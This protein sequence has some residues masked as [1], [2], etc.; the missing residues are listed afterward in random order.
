MT[1]DEPGERPP[2]WR[3]GGVHRRPSPLR[4]PH[5]RVPTKLAAV[6][7]V[8]LLG[9]LVVTGVQITDSVR[10][11]SGLN[12]FSQQVKLGVE[13]TGLVHELQ[14]ERDRTV[15]MLAALSARRSQQ[16]DVG[17]LAPEW[18]AVDRAVQ[19]LRARTRPLLGSDEALA[20]V[21]ARADVRLTDLARVRE[22]VTQGWLRTQAVFDLYSSTIADLQALLPAGDPGGDAELGRQVRG[23]TDLARAKEL[24][25][26][27]RGQLYLLCRSYGT[28][29]EN[30][31]DSRIA[32]LR[33]QRT[34][35]LARFRADAVPAQVARFDDTVAGQAVR[36][37][38]RLEQLIAE[39]GAAAERG[40]DAQQW[41]MASTTELQLLRTVEQILVDDAVA[42]VGGASGDLWRTTLIRSLTAIGLLL[43]A[44]MLSVVIGRNMAFTLRSLRE[45]A[46]VVAEVRLP[47]VIEQLRAS[48]SASA[49][50]RVDPIRVGSRDEVAEVADAF[51]AVHRSAVRLATEQAAMRRN[52]N[53]IF[54]KLALRSQSLVDRQLQL[55]DDMEHAEVDPDKLGNLFR[56]DHL[57]ARLR[58]NDENLLV[59]AGG[60]TARHWSRPRDLNEIVLAAAGEVEHYERVDH[61]IADRVHLVGHAVADVINLVAELLDNGLSFSP[62]DT[63]VEVHGHAR[64]DGTAELIITDDGIG[65]T[66]FA[67]AEANEQLGTPV[68][69]DSSAAERMGL[70]VVGH[71]ARRH[72]IGVGLHS[73]GRGVTVRVTLPASLLVP[74][75]DPADEPAPRR[76][77]PAR[78]AAAEPVAVPAERVPD[79][80]RLVQ[81]PRQA[82][83]RGEV[84]AEPDPAASVWWSRDAPAPT[85]TSTVL[86]PAPQVTALTEAGLPI[87]VRSGAPAAV[88]PAPLADEVDPDTL[89]DTLTRL[90][91]GIR[92]A[93][94]ED[95]ALEATL[96]EAVSAPP[97][98]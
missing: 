40:V 1:A 64:P 30:G 29:T 88:K 74:A 93:E 89:G 91:G 62:P 51:T 49:P 79:G 22:G 43:A 92:R 44:L 34:A 73:T 56:L 80:H 16:R 20:E 6:L 55:L 37:A 45:Q 63:R 70:V 42:A 48:T 54:I 82:Q 2:S 59:L 84:A 12:G 33:A 57:A 31:W 3:A 68:G 77:E 50:I 27:I 38:D 53:E 69:I 32:D 17:S 60:D 97:A 96:A 25:A 13:V 61:E 52:V 26:Q 75:P 65:M 9:F 28:P 18:T 86:T 58:R 39:E 10:A 72:G 90:A 46:L 7:T 14:R 19:Q 78:A 11:A 67:L 94:A 21:F 36:N 4:T 66:A 47:R 15:G 23:F 24:A 83:P 87:R 35:A 95:E 5:W 8:P 98:G 81:V 71:L 76:P 41:W 85:A